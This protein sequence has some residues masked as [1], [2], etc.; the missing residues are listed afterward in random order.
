MKPI[1]C[2]KINSDICLKSSCIGA[3]E[4]KIIDSKIDTIK[5]SKLTHIYIFIKSDDNLFCLTILH[6]K[7]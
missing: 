3:Y 4:C 5:K 2:Y 7:K 6:C 1:Y